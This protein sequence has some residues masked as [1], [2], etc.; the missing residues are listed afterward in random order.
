[1][2]ISNNIIIMNRGDTL[3]FDLTIA[4]TASANGRYILQGAD[5]VYFGVMEPGQPFEIA[6]I[7]K[8]FSTADLDPAGNLTIVLEP[9]DTIDLLPGKYF[10]AV[11]LHLYHAELDS[12]T[13][14]PTGNCID[15]VT[16]VINKTKF[17][18]C[19]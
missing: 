12:E 6:K 2:S 10:Y 9:A 11:K 4:D 14:L 17:I 19:D 16:T 5:T 7:R 15:K 13:G 1:M 18:L 8:S 3:E